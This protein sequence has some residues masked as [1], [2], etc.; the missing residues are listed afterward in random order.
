MITTHTKKEIC[1]YFKTWAGTKEFVTKRTPATIRKRHSDSEDTLLL[2]VWS[3]IAGK[4]P[5]FDACIKTGVGQ[6][7]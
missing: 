6:C 7:R 3:M 1:T 5:D 4:R 2:L